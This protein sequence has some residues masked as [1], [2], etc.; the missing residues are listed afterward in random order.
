MSNSKALSVVI[1]VISVYSHGLGC[2]HSCY[3]CQLTRP[4]MQSLL[5]PM[6]FPNNRDIVTA[7]VNVKSQSLDVVSIPKAWDVV[8][9]VISVSTF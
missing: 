5:M 3:H 6:S 1:A 8:I 4:G 9:A 7:V 2:S